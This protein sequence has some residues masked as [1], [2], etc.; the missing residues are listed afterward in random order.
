M[1]DHDSSSAEISSVAHRNAKPDPEDG[2]GDGDV[3]EL[4]SAGCEPARGPNSRPFEYP[5]KGQV[6][7]PPGRADGSASWVRSAAASC[8][9][10]ICNC[11]STYPRR[12]K[13]PSHSTSD[14][15]KVARIL[16]QFS[17]WR[18]PSR[19]VTQL[20]SPEADSDTSAISRS[21]TTG[22]PRCAGSGFFW[23]SFWLQSPSP[24]EFTPRQS[25]RSG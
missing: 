17:I 10:Q 16:G 21:G 20:L 7:K 24:L 11:A 1:P 2:G 6:S 4:S 3:E 5:E 18:R 13:F 23:F 14:L 8:R 19:L 12:V 22:K 25:A 9:N 15:Q